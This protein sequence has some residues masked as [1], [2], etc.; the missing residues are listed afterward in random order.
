MKITGFEIEHYEVESAPYRWRDGLIGGPGGKSRQT[1][2]RVKTDAGIDGLVWMSHEKISVELVRR[3][4]EPMFLGADP[5]MREKIWYEVWE[6]DR[7][8]E[9]PMYALGYLDVAVWDILAKAAGVPAYQILG[10]HKS[11]AKAYAST[12]T[13]ETVDDYLRLAD[14]CLERGYKAIKLHVWG[15][16]LDDIRLVRKL[17]RHVGPDVELMLDGSAGYNLEESVRLG[18]AMEEEGYLWLEEPM[19]EFNL[20][21]YEKLCDTLDIAILGAECTD[22][23]H[24]NAAEWL[25]RSACDRLRTSWFYKGGLTG[26]LKTAYVA[27]SF[28]VQADVHGC[29]YGSLHLICALPN[30][31]YYESLVPE[32][33][34]PEATLARPI[35]PDAEGWV[36]PNQTPGIGW[37]PDPQKR[38]G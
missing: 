28:Q 17:R 6:R 13:M 18:R 37:E 1:L 7:L 11:R 9:F 23:C 20:L 4:F 32:E 33:C 21:A 16:V 34:M 30:S 10:G 25:L 15:R 5:W 8:E 26:A 12:V 27:E 35:L 14:R 31:L 19:R 36:Y 24:F 22:G 2:L 38:I 29:G 3:C